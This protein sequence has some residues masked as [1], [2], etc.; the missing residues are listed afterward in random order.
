MAAREASPTDRGGPIDRQL[1][2]VAE[3][4]RLSAGRLQS[5]SGSIYS[6]SRIESLLC[7][8]VG[9]P[10]SWLYAHPEAPLS[11]EQGRHFHDQ[12]DRLMAGVP[13]EYLTGR[14][15]FR[16]I[17]LEVTPDVLVPRP[18]TETLV[19]AAVSRLRGTR[20]PRIADVGTGSGAIALALANEVPGARIVAVDLSLAA[21]RVAARNVQA[22]KQEGRVLLVNGDLMEGLAARFDLV[23]A[24]LPYVSDEDL[25]GPSAAVARHEPRLALAGGADGLDLVRRLLARLP[26]T[27]C[28]GGSALLEIGADQGA[29]AREAA[30]RA[31]AAATVEV[32]TD[33]WGR[34]R[35]LA[36]R[37][38]A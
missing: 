34:D 10:L 5:A 35:V 9:K 23:V 8:V 1:I 14:A 27:V 2:T 36:L 26:E 30:A 19:E 29:L 6:R 28:P 24:N 22:L 25:G 12:I 38:P 4:V 16:D 37:F 32:L 31:V 11:P 3:L 13:F 20:K 21:L 33:A 15:A 18:E 7:H 17:E